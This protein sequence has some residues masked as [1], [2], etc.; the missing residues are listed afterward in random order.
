MARPAQYNCNEVLWKATL[1]FWEKGYR[2]VSISD[3]VQATGLQPGSLYGRFGSKEGLFL[4]CIDHY[5]TMADRIR[6]Q[7]LEAPSPLARLRSF[8]DAMVDQAASEDGERGCFIVN[9]SLECEASETAIRTKVQ[10][11]MVRGEAWIR[12]QLDDAVAEG[13]LQGTTDTALLAGCLSSSFYGFR[14]ISRAGDGRERLPHIA[15]TT[16]ESLIGPWRTELVS[17]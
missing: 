11:C 14:V 10:D 9:A 1:L 4:E 8:Y 16:F 15:A 13:E 17:A 12:Q 6:D 7:H 2:A 5:Q 3:L